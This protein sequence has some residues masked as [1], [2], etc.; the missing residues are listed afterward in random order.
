VG[1]SRRGVGFS[2]VMG[3][4]SRESLAAGVIRRREEEG[5]EG[6]LLVFV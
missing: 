6:R 1:S 5:G 4:G 2:K 3:S